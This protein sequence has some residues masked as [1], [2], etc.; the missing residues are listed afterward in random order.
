MK[1][2]G[3]ASALLIALLL[4]FVWAGDAQAQTAASDLAG[5]SWQLVKFEGSDASTLTPED[6]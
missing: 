6:G 5:T 1:H 3:L 2:I 4:Q